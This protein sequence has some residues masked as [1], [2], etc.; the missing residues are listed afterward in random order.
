VPITHWSIK[1]LKRHLRK[2]FLQATGFGASVISCSLFQVVGV[3][4][5]K[6]DFNIISL[7]MRPLARLPPNF[8]KFSSDN[9]KHLFLASPQNREMDIS[10]ILVNK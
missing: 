7:Q 6:A 9:A 4:Y 5:R 2:G 10:I 8:E 3:A 1:H